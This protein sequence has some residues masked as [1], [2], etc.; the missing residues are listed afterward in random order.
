MADRLP[1]GDNERR[2]LLEEKK[3]ELAR[4]RQARLQQTAAA[5]P[6]QHFAN[7]RPSTVA[8]EMRNIL[9]NVGHGSPDHPPNN[10]PNGNSSMLNG[11]ISE[12]Q[13]D[14][15]P[16]ISPPRRP[17]RLLHKLEMGETQQ[18]FS[19]QPKEGMAYSKTTQTEDERVSV[20][21]FSMGSQEFDYDEFS[22]GDKVDINF[23]ESPSN[24][25][26]KLLPSFGLRGLPDHTLVEPEPEERIPE[27]SKEEK[28]QILQS[29]EF[30][31]FFAKAG[32][33]LERELAELVDTCVDYGHDF[34]IDGRAGTGELL[35]LNREFYDESVKNRYVS[36]IDF[37]TFHPEL[38]AT[39]YDRRNDGE[40]LS[41]AGIVHVWNSKFKVDRPEYTFHSPSR[42]TSLQFARFHSNIIVGGLYSGQICIWDNRVNKKT[43][44]QKSPL[45]A[46]SHTQPVYCMSIVGSQ[47][48]HD[49]VTISTDGRICSW[50]LD[51]LS[52]PISGE[53]LAYKTKRNLSVTSLCFLNNNI[54]S[55]VTG[56]D[57]GAMYFGDRHGQKGEMVKS[58]ELHKSPISAVD[59][60]HAAGATTD[61]SSLCLTASWDSTVKLTN[62][63]DDKPLLSLEQHRDYVLDVKWSPVHPATFASIDSEGQLNLWNLNQD[64]ESPVSSLSVGGYCSGSRVL[65]SANGQQLA[66]GDAKGR[67]LLFDVNESLYNV[68]NDEW[69]KFTNTLHEIKV[70]SLNDVL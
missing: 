62:L 70:M 57:E 69:D 3:R 13:N 68:R 51:N 59:T 31:S 24:E 67:V 65:W 29:D 36:A 33:I 41:H 30:L 42:I 45:S 22:M 15:T 48:A 2:Q 55:F 21:E 25:I 1:A 4:I 14:K 5:R 7:G 17:N 43:P 8:E 34:T 23:D 19:V 52:T 53:N 63:E 60:H 26:A 37:S 56:S 12:S 58:Y 49:L 32:K 46:T 44:V 27:L 66:V 61:F 35:T 40:K 39:A 10:L 54:T 28:K 38:I 9:A 16:T 64:T 50:A 20:G 47:N 11:T 6:D 18:I